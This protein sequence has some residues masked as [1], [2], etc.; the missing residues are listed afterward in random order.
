M[1]ESQKLTRLE[2]VE[3]PVV[4]PCVKILKP[5]STQGHEYL[6]LGLTLYSGEDF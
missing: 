3:A 1:G 6:I 5:P 4:N 2:L